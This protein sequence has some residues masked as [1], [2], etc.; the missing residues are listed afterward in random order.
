MI[1]STDGSMGSAGSTDLNPPMD[2]WIPLVRQTV[3]A[4]IHPSKYSAWTKVSSHN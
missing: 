1:E 4:K 2:P 3:P